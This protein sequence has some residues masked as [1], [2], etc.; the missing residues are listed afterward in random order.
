[1]PQAALERW[2]LRAVILIVGA[3][4]ALMG[5]SLL[6]AGARRF[7]S[8]GFATAR[9]VPGGVYT[10]GVLILIAGVATLIGAGAWHPHIL[11]WSCLGMA[12]W[13]LWFD[14]SLIVTSAPD[15]KGSVTGA[16]VYL[17]V[18]ALCLLLWSTAGS[19]RDPRMRKAVVGDPGT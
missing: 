18:T 9:L 15:P 14:I 10:W 12:F 2:L 19:I 3:G 13:Y 8:P 1:M 4:S 5:V 7:T 17:M 6:A 11:R 16:V